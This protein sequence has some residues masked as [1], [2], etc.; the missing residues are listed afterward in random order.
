MRKNPFPPNFFFQKGEAKANLLRVQ[1][2]NHYPNLCI[3]IN[4]FIHRDFALS[5]LP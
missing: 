4:K 5:I 3:M 1:A 2:E